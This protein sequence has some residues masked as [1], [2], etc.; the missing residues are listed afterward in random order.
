MK[1][2]EGVPLGK[3]NHLVHAYV[4]DGMVGSAWTP[5][6]E[7]PQPMVAFA[8]NL[9][10]IPKDDPRPRCQVCFPP[11]RP[12]PKTGG[13]QPTEEAPENPKPPSPPATVP[14][15]S[16]GLGAV[17]ARLKERRQVMVDAAANKAME[18]AREPIVR[19][20]PPKPI[21]VIPPP[22]PPQAPLWVIRWR[23]HGFDGPAVFHATIEAPDAK[24]AVS[25]LRRLCATPDLEIL[26]CFES[27][28]PPHGSP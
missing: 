16:N 20:V 23:P 3:G 19:I 27:R 17:A 14:A 12:E 2:I 8:G 21:A 4:Y 1:T 13:Y 11:F 18:T 26:S 22:A 24:E 10:V 7:C 6:N 5:R 9:R 28:L 15:G 25:S